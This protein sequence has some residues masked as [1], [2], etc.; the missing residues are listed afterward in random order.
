MEGCPVKFALG[1]VS[2]K[3]KLRILWELNQQ[4]VIRFNELQRRLSGISS[5]MLS[6][7]LEELEQYPEIPPKVEYSLTE[8]GRS[9]DPALQALGAWG[10]QA[11][12]QIHAT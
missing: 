8:L 10:T 3:W 12:E 1:L 2:G 6:K 5:V 7:S 9:I 4:E 11:Y